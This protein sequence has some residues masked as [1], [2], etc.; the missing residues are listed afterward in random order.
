MLIV[1]DRVAEARQHCRAGNLQAAMDLYSSLLAESPRRAD[2]YFER[3]VVAQLGQAPAVAERDFRVC[4]GLEPGHFRAREHLGEIRRRMEPFVGSRAE[5]QHSEP[6]IYAVG[7]SYIRAFS[8]TTLFLPLWL[9]PANDLS[10]ISGDRAART[11]AHLF[12]AIDRCDLR[13]PVM[14]VMGNNDA[15]MHANNLAGTKDPQPDGTAARH[16][17][18]LEAGALRY[19]AAI[20]NMLR[21]YPGIELLV[22]GGFL[23]FSPEKMNTPASPIAFSKNIARGSV[24]SSSISTR[25]WP[26]PPPERCEPNSRVIRTTSI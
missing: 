24:C 13:N 6:F 18:V 25:P 16:C 14:L 15:I 5:P 26:I 12:A 17:D 23:A 10:F 1:D 19:V 8:S 3:G 9:G 2:L 22:T 20:E 21:R 7:S 4:L 11:Q